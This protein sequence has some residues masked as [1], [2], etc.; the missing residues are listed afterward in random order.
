M[1]AFLFLL[2]ALGISAVAFFLPAN[3]LR[4]INGL[5]AVLLLLSVVSRIT[6]LREGRKFEQKH[7]AA[8]E[9]RYQRERR[10]AWA[11]SIAALELDIFGETYYHDR[12]Y[13]R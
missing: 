7:L 13:L 11:S 6:W 2:F 12:E 10:A 9:E 4:P 1:K 3:P 8:V 5:I